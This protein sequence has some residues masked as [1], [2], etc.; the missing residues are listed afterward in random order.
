MYIKLCVLQR[1]LE[2]GRT[3][4]HHPQLAYRVRHAFVLEL[5]PEGRTLRVDVGIGPGD[6]T[7]RNDAKAA[8]HERDS[9][10]AMV[11]LDFGAKAKT[12]H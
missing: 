6:G 2:I 12:S 7:N 11:V 5:L 9:I 3:I 4:P 8:E 10:Y 1:I